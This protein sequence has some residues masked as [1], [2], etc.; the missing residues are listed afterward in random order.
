M[1]TIAAIASVKPTM[2]AT[3]TSVSVNG[4]L[5]DGWAAIP[6]LCWAEEEMAAVITAD[7]GVPVGAE[8][9]VLGAGVGDVLGAGGIVT[10]PLSG[11]G[12]TDGL[13]LVPAPPV[14]G[15]NV[16]G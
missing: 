10:P 5:C 15:G 12:W 14:L 7:P 13:G 9:A 2:S 8:V 6:G 16:G 4:Q 1:K 11:A 3:S